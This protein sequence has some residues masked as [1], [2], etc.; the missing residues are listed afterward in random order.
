MLRAAQHHIK[1]LK[2][3]AGRGADEAV[4]MQTAC[5]S[6][7]PQGVVLTRQGARKAIK[8]LLSQGAILVVRGR[9]GGGRGR[10]AILVVRGEPPQT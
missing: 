9:G 3:P 4:L 10:G 1:H 2:S 8:K 7:P 6:P 5:R